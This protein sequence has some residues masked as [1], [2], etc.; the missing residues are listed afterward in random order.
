MHAYTYI[1]EESE[2]SNKKV[3]VENPPLSKLHYANCYYSVRLWKNAS[4][5]FSISGIEIQQ[6]PG[7]SAGHPLAFLKA[8]RGSHETPRPRAAAAGEG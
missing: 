1:L 8:L 7:P 3:S 4:S 5:G 6:L 2:L